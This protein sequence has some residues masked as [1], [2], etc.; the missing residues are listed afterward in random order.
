MVRPTNDYMKH[1]TNPAYFHLWELLKCVCFFSHPSHVLRKRRWNV[2]YNYLNNSTITNKQTLI[3][4][5][6]ELVK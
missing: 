1:F 5:R 2:T 4:S 6:V 3:I